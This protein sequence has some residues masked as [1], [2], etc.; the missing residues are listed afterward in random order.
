ML[1]LCPYINQKWCW[2]RGNRLLDLSVVVFSLRSKRNGVLNVIVRD[3]IV[4]IQEIWWQTLFQILSVLV[5]EHLFC[6]LVLRV[7][8][9]GVCVLSFCV[10]PPS[11]LCVFLGNC[12][13]NTAHLLVVLLI[14]SLPAQMAYRD[15]G[16]SL[17]CRTSP[18]SFLLF[19]FAYAV[20][21]LV[22]FGLFK[23][24]PLCN[25]RFRDRLVG[26]VPYTY[27]CTYTSLQT[28]RWLLLRLS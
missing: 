13:R 14:G 15:R 25:G 6:D 11:S 20:A 24:C 8:Q 4:S 2:L 9:P 28:C 22:C 16:D 18:V 27:T 21:A 23:T 26:R 10:P 5:Y 12:C 3:Y 1:C 7:R 17:K 19:S